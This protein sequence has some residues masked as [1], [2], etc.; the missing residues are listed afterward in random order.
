[1][2]NGCT[3]KAPLNLPPPAWVLAPLGESELWAD[4]WLGGVARHSGEGPVLPYPSLKECH[5]TAS[6]ARLVCKQAEVVLRTQWSGCTEDNA[7]Q[8]KYVEH[9]WKG[10]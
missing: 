8:H 10:L 5:Q 7:V 6:L 9:L 2:N 3:D 1:M 4:K